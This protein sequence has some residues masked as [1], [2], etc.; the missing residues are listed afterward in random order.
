MIGY[1]CSWKKRVAFVEVFK[2]MN[3]QNSKLLLLYDSNR[4][5]PALYGQPLLF[6]SKL[7]RF[8]YMGGVSLFGD[9]VQDLTLLCFSVICS[10]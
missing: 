1:V 3:F 9:L 5:I 8:P 7:Q 4:F 2:R 6:W 10:E